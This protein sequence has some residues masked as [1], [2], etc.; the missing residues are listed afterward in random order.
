MDA[1]KILGSSE[2]VSR[3]LCYRLSLIPDQ[4]FLQSR[5]GPGGKR[6]Y[7]ITVQNLIAIANDVF[8][9]TGWSTDCFLV[10]T[11]V[12]SKDGKF[13]VIAK[14]KVKVKV[15][16][17][18]HSVIGYGKGISSD[19]VDAIAKAEK[20]ARSDGLKGALKMF[21]N[22]FGLFLKDVDLLK[23]VLR[24]TVPPDRTYV[25]DMF[26][27]SSV[28]NHPVAVHASD[29]KVKRE[30]SPLLSAKK[31]LL[32]ICELSAS[33]STNMRYFSVDVDDLMSTIDPTDFCDDDLFV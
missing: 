28:A 27:Q 26:S 32:G 8:G 15:A 29:C 33:A 2:D 16:C 7:Y 6:F 10:N 4:E 12:E 9:P 21:G 11:V 25:K 18:S 22:V 23:S 5:P 13:D 3:D 30:Q 24:G 17:N 1:V 14:V 19:K 20:V 31:T